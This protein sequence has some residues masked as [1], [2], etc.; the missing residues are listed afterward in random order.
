MTNGAAWLSD[1]ENGDAYEG[2]SASQLPAVAGYPHLTVPGGTIGDLPV[3][4]SF[5]A[6]KWQDA[7]VLSAGYAFEQARPR[8]VTPGFIATTG[9]SPEAATAQ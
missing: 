1:L 7:K 3:G 4:I 8:I 9:E 6:G 2:P 5:I